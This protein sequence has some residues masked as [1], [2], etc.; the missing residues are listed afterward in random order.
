MTLR[1]EIIKK[2]LSKISTLVIE[3]LKDDFQ[4]ND[5]QIDVFIECLSKRIKISTKKS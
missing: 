4:F 2:G 1:D 5:N 3:T